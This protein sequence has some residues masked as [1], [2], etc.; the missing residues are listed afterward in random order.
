V[1]MT[2][3]V[4]FELDALTYDFVIIAS[5]NNAAAR[6]AS[7]AVT[8]QIVDIN[9]NAPLFNATAVAMETVYERRYSN[10]D[11]KGTVITTVSATDADSGTNAAFTF[12]IDG[13]NTDDFFA[14]DADTG[15]ITLD[16]SNAE[17]ATHPRFE[18]LVTATDQG[19]PVLTTDATI[20]IA[21]S[22]FQMF[23]ET[24]LKVTVNEYAAKGAVCLFIF[25]L[26]GC[27]FGLGDSM[28]VFR[29]PA[30]QRHTSSRGQTAFLFAP[31]HC[32]APAG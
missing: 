3:V 12:S 31:E 26:G 6:E 24:V 27:T 1:Y 5:E 17:R 32:A 20:T 18:L 28:T 16:A 25:L 23:P 13:G 4:D 8:V 11:V 21:V 10:N 30:V 14:I 2:A 15:E 9:D 29:T 7:I 19:V 22:M